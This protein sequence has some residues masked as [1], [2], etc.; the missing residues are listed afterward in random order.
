MQLDRDDSEQS[1]KQAAP[2]RQLTWQLPSEQA[3]VQLEPAPHSQSPLAQTPEQEGLSPSQFTW[4]GPASQTNAQRAPGA[5]EQVP[6]AQVP[7]QVES[8]AQS[9]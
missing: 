5:Q 7:E 3:K 8:G 1:S 4:H 9:T 6:F 2:A